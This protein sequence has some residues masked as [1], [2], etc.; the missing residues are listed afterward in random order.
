MRTNFTQKKQCLMMFNIAQKV[1]YHG[2]AQYLGLVP[3][4]SN[5]FVTSNTIRVMWTKFSVVSSCNTTALKNDS[6]VTQQ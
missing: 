6:F 1:K 5:L 4:S 3:P 2:W